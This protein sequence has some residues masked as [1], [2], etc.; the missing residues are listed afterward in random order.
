MYEHHAD[1][2][3][4]PRP[5]PYRR[6]LEWLT[7]QSL[8]ESRAAWADVLDG[9]EG[10][11]I[12]LPSARGR[13]PSTFP[14]E[15]R[16]SLSR[17]HTDGLRTVARTHDLT[18]HTIL[19]TAWALVLATHTATTDITFGTTVSG[20]PP[21]IPG[22][23][24]MIGLFINTIPVRI[25]LHPTD[26]LTTLLHHTHATHTQLLDHHHLPPHPHPPTPHAT[27]FD[28]I[29]VHENYPPPHHPTHRPHHHHHLRHRRHPLPPSHS[30]PPPPT[31]HSTSSSSFCRSS[32]AATTPRR[33]RPTCAGHWR[34]SRRHRRR[35]SRRCG[36]SATTS[37]VRSRPCAAVPHPPPARS[38]RSSPTPQPSI[39]TPSRSRTPVAR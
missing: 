6:Y 20:R 30:P 37:S 3:A 14:D 23:E 12:L 4:V 17:E 19:D 35:P 15:Y 34:S 32:S 38:P 22:I 25:T 8:E 16:V 13:V 1:P 11:T 39:R 26:T 2:G 21:H 28:T 10:P 7:Q 31:P 18:L 29:T 36:F 9:L 27:T 33:S 24:T 5:L